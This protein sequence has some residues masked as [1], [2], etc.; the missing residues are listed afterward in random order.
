MAER[1]YVSGHA[2]P[3]HHPRREEPISHLPEEEFLARIR[4]HYGTPAEAFDDPQLVK[5]LVPMMRADFTLAETYE[6]ALD[7]VLGSP[8][9]AMGGL[10]DPDAPGPELVGWRAYTRRSFRVQMFPGDHFFLHTAENELLEAFT[11]DLTGHDAP[12][13]RLH[14]VSERTSR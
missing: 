9:T 13:R 7:H 12:H 10:E 5:L 6:Q 2:A 3:P 4:D 1:L 8:V 11:D 14:P